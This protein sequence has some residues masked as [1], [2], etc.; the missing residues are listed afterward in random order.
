VLSLVIALAPPIVVPVAAQGPA[1]AGATFTP[2]P[3]TYQPPRTPWG[4]PDLMGVW[5]YQSAI[6]MQR[7]ANLAG[8]PKFNSDAEYEAWLKTNAPNRDACGIGT[9]ANE[10]CPENAPP[11]ITYNEFWNQRNFV[12]N[13]NTALIVD[14]PDGRYPPLTPQAQERQKEILA[15]TRDKET[16]TDYHGLDRCIATQT[17]NGPQAYNSGTYIMQSPDSVMIV[18][19]RLDTRF[20]WLDGRPHIS[21][22]IRQWNGDSIGHWE[23]N[24][25][26]VET[27]NFTN[28]QRLGGASGTSVPAGI[29]F[30]NFRVIEYFV[31]VSA[32]RIEYYATVIDPTT[33]TKA[34][35]FNL[36]W[37]RDDD[38][39]I[40]EY[41]C[42]EGNIALENSL[43]GD[44]VLK[45][46]AEAAK[47]KE[48]K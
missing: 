14:P 42:H 20:I 21:E 28:E 46:K 43:R 2:P 23:G 29:P 45:A 5:D 33:W 8:K 7:P 16:W 35:T 3:S 47:K 24:T 1:F 36:P 37:Q 6:R 10:K 4:H 39:Q 41:G 19:E 31:P 18:R 12:K 13:Y 9:R 15:A 40:L 11:D 32:N 34:W 30:G 22:K 48:N 25:L 17:P 26:V 44:R 38:Y 27:T